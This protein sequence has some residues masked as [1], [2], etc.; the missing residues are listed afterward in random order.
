MQIIYILVNVS[1]LE[2]FMET[3]KSCGLNDF[4]II[5]KMLSV[6][7]YGNPR[8]NTSVWPGF[9]SGILIQTDE[10][11]KISVLLNEIRHYNQNRLNDDEIIKAFVW[12]TDQFIT[13]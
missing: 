10:D 6:S 4:Q 5:E 12:K 11:D 3:I 2:S 8:M 9:S 7:S 1:I 13:E